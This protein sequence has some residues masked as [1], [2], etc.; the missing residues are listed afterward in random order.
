MDKAAFI[1]HVSDYGRQEMEAQFPA[2]AGKMPDDAILFARN[3]G[4]AELLDY[5]AARPKAVVLEEGSKTAHVTI[6]ARAIG[7]PMRTLPV[8]AP[9]RPPPSCARRTSCR[10]GRAGS[11]A[12]ASSSIVTASSDPV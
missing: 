5:E 12:P 3:M 6:V 2:A 9:L 8:P 10:P 1:V 4:P 7:V 11:S